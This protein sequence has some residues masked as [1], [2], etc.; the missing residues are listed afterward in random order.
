MQRTLSLSYLKSFL[1]AALFFAVLSVAIDWWRKP[2]QP[3][4]FSDQT[5][6]T[7][8]QNSI[9]LR[10]L[11]QNRIIIV[12][13]WG[14]WC[15]ICKYTSPTIEK[16][17]QNHIPIISI[18]VKSGNNAALKHYLSHNG[19]SFPTV[20]DSDGLISHQWNI[21]V[22]PTIV[23]MKNGQMLHSTTGI[24]SYWG[25]RLRMLISDLIY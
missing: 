13:F 3:V 17:H 6:I 24:S 25:L 9:S 5:L 21:S 22:T 4:S 12:Y 14:T 1:Q 16:L 7:L 15:S 18:A 2:N 10:H 23:L 20:N 19:L 11:S 8:H